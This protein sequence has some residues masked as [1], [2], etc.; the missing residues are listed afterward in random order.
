MYLEIMNYLS[1]IYNTTFYV[2]FYTNLTLIELI[3]NIEKWK[4]LC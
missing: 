1:Q 3:F 4:N 2:L